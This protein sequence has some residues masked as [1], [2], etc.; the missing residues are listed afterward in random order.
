MSFDPLRAE[1]LERNN[2]NN[3]AA[4]VDLTIALGANSKNHDAMER[5]GW[6]LEVALDRAL[7]IIADPTLDRD[8]VRTFV[9]INAKVNGL[10]LHEAD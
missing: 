4:A 5:L 10:V 6:P 9:K 1:F 8:R 7:D 2:G 3:F